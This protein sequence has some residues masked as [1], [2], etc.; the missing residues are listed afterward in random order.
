METAGSLDPEE[1]CNQLLSLRGIS[2]EASDAFL[3]PRLDD[4]TLESVG[5]SDDACQTIIRR[6]KTAVEHNEQIVVYGDYDV[7][8]ITA[9]A[10]L[11]ETLHVLTPRVVPYI[12]HRIDEGYGLSKKGIDQLS[13]KYP[14][15]GVLI[16]VDNG[17]V[18]HE[19]VGYAHEH[20]WDV[21]ITDHHAP[22][23]TL[24]DAYAIFHTTRLCGAGVA[25]LLRNRILA[26]MDHPH[27]PSHLDLVALATV[28]D[29]VPLTGANRTLLHFGL[30]KLQNDTSLRPGL[31]ALYQEAGISAHEID[32]YHIGHIIA[33]RLNAMGRLES[34]MDSLRLLC[35]RDT[36]RAEDLAH[37][38]GETNRG[39]Q[40]LTMEG[41][42]RAIERQRKYADAAQLIIEVGK[43]EEGII[44][45]IAGRLVEEYY[46]PSIVISKGE[47]VSKAS[48]RSVKG[49][50]IIETIRAHDHMLINAGGHPMAAG[51]TIATER[52][53]EFVR[54]LQEASRSML[55]EIILERERVI[56]LLLPLSAVDI[57]LYTKL[58]ELA[59]FGMG[60]PEP[61][62]M[63]EG[64]QLS[65]VRTVGK[66]K[67]H[68]SCDAET[69]DGYRVSL[70]GFN[71]ADEIRNIDTSQGVDIVYTIGQ[72]TWNGRSKLQLTLKDIRQHTAG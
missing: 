29:L 34:A 28:A 20:Q 51:F 5:L 25:Y 23:E 62:F 59:P 55:T 6:I 9:S 46:R 1:I 11:W 39:R 45:L 70:I 72:N 38:L 61:V 19:A 12:P 32:T 2:S 24:P 43:Y 30:K 60:N 26:S 18:A 14:Q 4:V 50:N 15:G 71:L 54:T 49:F 17:I 44:G 41:S 65:S 57:S 53:D 47:A 35:T 48:A 31:R 63:S 22:S 58:R 52:I 21:I 66:E 40:L 36:K 10:I 33:P 16:T 68:I 56:D 42:L 64:V 13:L 67:N 69:G 7:D 8:G 37:L 27:V 3:R